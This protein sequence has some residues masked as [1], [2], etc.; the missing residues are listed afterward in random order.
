MPP[1]KA[2]VSDTND[3]APRG[4]VVT[5]HAAIYAELKSSLMNGDFKPGERLIVRELSERFATS[6]MPVREALRKL[7]NDE[8]LF[9]HPNRGVTVPAADVG[10]I[11]DLFRVRC[12]IEGQAA[13][14]A[15]ATISKAELDAVYSINE[16]MQTCVQ[17]SEVSHYLAL[18]KQFH[19]TI[20]R[21]SKS[22]V[23][24]PIIER[25][26]LRAGPLLNIMRQEATI[27]QG[28][29]HHTDI[30]EA[31]SKGQ[32]TQSRRAMV[33]DIADAS[34]I[35]QRAVPYWEPQSETKQQ[36]A[37]DTDLSADK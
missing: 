12:A 35:L 7:V 36:A 4:E 10:A 19:F 18:N 33:A 29:D 34:D 32:G 15:A 24:L 21:A 9:D 20:Y 8:A 30:L 6:T 25:L 31:I 16:A 3:P 22:N 2:H 17:T 11:A 37:E 1:R 13:E 23:L 27:Q 26:W 14:W 28:L 5:A